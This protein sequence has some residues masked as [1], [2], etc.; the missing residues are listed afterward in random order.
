M[1]DNE[2]VT[3]KRLTARQLESVFLQLLKDSRVVEK[4]RLCQAPVGALV[5]FYKRHDRCVGR[6]ASTERGSFS[7][8]SMSTSGLT[9]MHREANATAAQMSYLIRCIENA[10]D[11][12][13]ESTPNENPCC[14]IALP[15]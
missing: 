8:I 13:F 4:H 15:Q 6:W 2:G 1:A 11:G 12:I 10:A 5:G 9:Y 7:Y 14:E 3:S